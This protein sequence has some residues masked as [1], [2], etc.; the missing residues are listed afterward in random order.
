[1]SRIGQELLR[2][3][4][5]SIHEKGEAR[6]LLSLLVKSNIATDIPEH[7]RMT[8]QDVLA[9]VPTFLVAGHETTS[10]ATTW[11]L[12][13]LTQNQA[14][15]NKLREELLMVET[16]NPTMEQLNA[17]KRRAFKQC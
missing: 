17:N 13:A 15:Q 5:A 6:D 8:D 14:A 4:K 9:Q 1:M 11:T 16:D 7:Q 2:E 10:T 3:S 12:Y